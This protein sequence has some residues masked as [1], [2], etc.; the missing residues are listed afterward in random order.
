VG[1][2]HLVLHQTLHQILLGI[3]VPSTQARRADAA[4]LNI[5]PRRI[6]FFLSSS[7][8]A[9][10]EVLVCGSLAIDCQMLFV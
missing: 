9:R 2:L 6:R 1:L 4:D 5:L 3:A 7:F 8:L 10:V